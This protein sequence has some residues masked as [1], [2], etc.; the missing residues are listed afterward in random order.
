[1]ADEKRNI[2]HQSSAKWAQNSSQQIETWGKVIREGTTECWRT[3]LSFNIISSTR[4][5]KL[6]TVRARQRQQKQKKIQS[7]LVVVALRSFELLARFI[8]RCSPTSSLLSMINEDCINKF[9]Y[10]LRHIANDNSSLFLQNLLMFCHIRWWWNAVKHSKTRT[11]RNVRG[12]R[13]KK[14]QFFAT[15]ERGKMIVSSSR[16]SSHKKKRKNRQFAET[17]WRESEQARQRSKWWWRVE[18]R[19]STEHNS[20]KKTKPTVLILETMWQ[21]TAINSH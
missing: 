4:H 9:L 14:K 3:T 16:C 2:R 5:W 21:F 12:K 8:L 10:H 11:N 17:K 20:E 15:N 18:T 7:N 1:M 13:R 19:A 6:H